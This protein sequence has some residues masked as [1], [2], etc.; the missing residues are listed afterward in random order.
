MSR[1]YPRHTSNAGVSKEVASFLKENDAI[2]VEREVQ[3][4]Y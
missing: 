3:R 1:K 4:W 2:L